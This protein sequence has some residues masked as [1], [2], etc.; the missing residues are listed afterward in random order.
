M[1]RAAFEAQWYSV[2]SSTALR[3][4]E[5]HMVTFCH[6]ACI[7]CLLCTERG[8]ICGVMWV[9]LFDD[10]YLRQRLLQHR[11]LSVLLSALQ[12]QLQQCLRLDRLVGLFGRDV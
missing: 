6:V 9:Q 12:R 4:N 3:S 5:V 8:R 1:N 11:D 2:S 7:K 10:Y